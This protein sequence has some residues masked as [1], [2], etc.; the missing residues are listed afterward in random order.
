MSYTNLTELRQWMSAAYTRPLIFV[1][2][3]FEHKCNNHN[4]LTEV[5]LSI[6]DTANILP[7]ATPTSSLQYTAVLTSHIKS[8]HLRVAE[9]YKWINRW[10]HGANPDGFQTEFGKS[11]KVPER[12]I[13]ARMEE[14]IWKGGR[15]PKR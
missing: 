9:H 3:D 1:A 6:L 4:V 13:V 12:R 8:Y 10:L 7:P 14:I 2:V 5:G 15:G 11:E